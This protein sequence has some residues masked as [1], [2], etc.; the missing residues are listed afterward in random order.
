MIR[1]DKQGELFVSTG[2]HG[3]I[4]WP[5]LAQRKCVERIKKYG[6]EWT[7]KA[8][9]FLAFGETCLALHASYNPELPVVVFNLETQSFTSGETC[10][11]LDAPYKPEFPF[12]KF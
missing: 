9:P 11:A 12:F 5:D 4:R 7:W 2:P 8:E 10:I 1:D 6:F 3:S